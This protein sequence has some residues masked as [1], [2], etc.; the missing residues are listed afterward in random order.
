MKKVFVLLQID[1]PKEGSAKCPDGRD[2]IIGV[3]KSVR[4]ASQEARERA[5]KILRF[6]RTDDTEFTNFK[7]WQCYDSEPMYYIEEVAIK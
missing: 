6:V 1:F 4:T 2:L 7:T 5:G 3:Y